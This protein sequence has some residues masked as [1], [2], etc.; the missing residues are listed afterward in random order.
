MQAGLDL[1]ERGVTA[2]LASDLIMPGGMDGPAFAQEARRRRPELPAILASGYGTS[3][4]RATELGYALHIKPFEVTGLAR[5]IRAHLVRG[6]RQ[7][8]TVVTLPAP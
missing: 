5:G 7:T 8:A 1:L 6:D 2:I 4:A 3:V